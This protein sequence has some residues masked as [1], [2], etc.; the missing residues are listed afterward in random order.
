MDPYYR[1]IEVFT[2]NNNGEK[3]GS[4]IVAVPQ[5]DENDDNHIG[6]VFRAKSVTAF[7]PIKSEP[8]QGRL[9]RS[10]SSNQLARQGQQMQVQVNRLNFAEPEVNGNGKRG[11]PHNLTED[12]DIQEPP[13]ARLRSSFASA[14]R[15]PE[16]EPEQQGGKTEVIYS[17]ADRRFLHNH[18]IRLTARQLRQ[19][20]NVIGRS[21]AD[22]NAEKSAADFKTRIQEPQDKLG[23]VC[24]LNFWLVDALHTTRVSEINKAKFIGNIINDVGI[25]YNTYVSRAF[26]NNLDFKKPQYNLTKF[27]DNIAS[28]VAWLNN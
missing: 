19:A 13:S 22:R 27:K 3:V 4:E 2:L 16:P 9:Q 24:S 23:L 26:I 18:T 28:W 8:T 10:N 25:Y 1:T 5:P 20:E 12:Q 14:A 15:R 6:T 17:N 21:G 11:S 7:T